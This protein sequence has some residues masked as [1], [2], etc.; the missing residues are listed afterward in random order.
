LHELLPAA[1]VMALLV[2]PE[3]GALAQGQSR[4]VAGMPPR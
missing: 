3:D 2:N 4:E 1:R